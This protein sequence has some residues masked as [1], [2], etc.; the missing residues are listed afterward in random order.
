MASF[1]RC[2]VADPLPGADREFRQLLLT[3]E[4]GLDMEGV[5]D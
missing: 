4:H 3:A 5:T 1:Q 2:G